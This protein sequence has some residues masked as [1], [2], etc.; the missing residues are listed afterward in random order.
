MD[1]LIDSKLVHVVILRPCLFCMSQN[2]IFKQISS[3]KNNCEVKNVMDIM[4]TLVRG[5]F[6]VWFEGCGS[7]DVGYYLM[8]VVLVMEDLYTISISGLSGVSENREWMARC[9]CSFVLNLFPV[10]CL[11]LGC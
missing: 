10:S 3:Q 2:V 5:L 6:F 8:L 1:G 4:V 9:L 7:F 11:K